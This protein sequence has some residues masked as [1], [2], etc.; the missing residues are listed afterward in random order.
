M[1]VYESIEFV[2]KLIN[3]AYIVIIDHEYLARINFKV[4]SIS[5]GGANPYLL[6][7]LRAAAGHLR[8]I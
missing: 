5:A 3:G 4:T 2:R 6:L 1:D 7:S 8:P